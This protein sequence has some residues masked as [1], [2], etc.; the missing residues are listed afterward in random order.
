MRQ[1][2]RVLALGTLLALPVWAGRELD[3][4]FGMYNGDFKAKSVK[5]RQPDVEEKELSNIPFSLRE[6]NLQLMI[7]VETIENARVDQIY[8][9]GYK[10]EITARQVDGDKRY[11]LFIEGSIA[12]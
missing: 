12:R 3:N 1:W 8:T 10:T 7:D 4:R 6:R 5:V 9:T 2:M 11:F